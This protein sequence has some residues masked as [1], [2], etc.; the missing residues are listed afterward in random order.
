MF[1]D[2][3]HNDEAAGDG[4][5]GVVIDVKSIQYYIMAENEEAVGLMPERAGF[6]FLEIKN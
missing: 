4:I 1:D 5:F 3:K 2:G 6:E